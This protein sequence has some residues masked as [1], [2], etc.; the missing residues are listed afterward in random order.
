MRTHVVVG[1]LAGI[2]LTAQVGILRSDPGRE[3]E[4]DRIARLVRQ[5]GDDS[6]EKREAASRELDAIGEP[7]VAALRKAA[8]S[9][10]DPEI[11]WRAATQ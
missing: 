11:R 2:L 10:D 8:A 3:T 6:F 4:T 7:A 5:L 9:S 1:V